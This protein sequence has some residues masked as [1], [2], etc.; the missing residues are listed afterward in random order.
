MNFCSFFSLCVCAFN[1]CSLQTLRGSRALNLLQLCHLDPLDFVFDCYSLTFS[2][3]QKIFRVC[4]GVSRYLL[5]NSTV[6]SCF[7]ISN[8]AA[9]EISLN[10][11][12][13]LNHVQEPKLELIG[14][15]V[16]RV[17][18]RLLEAYPLPFN[19][20]SLGVAYRGDP[21]TLLKSGVRLCGVDCLASSW[22]VQ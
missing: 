17:S 7:K 12:C 18:H 2:S 16:N 14:R 4:L 21:G 8:T 1:F 3:I 6:G 10:F 20:I 15:K 5:Q 13:P 19:T 9:S 22:M 11:T